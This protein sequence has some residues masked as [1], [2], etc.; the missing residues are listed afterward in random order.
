MISFL[1]FQSEQENG[2]KS[3]ESEEEPLTPKAIHSP[4]YQMFLSDPIKNGASGPGGPTDTNTTANGTLS[5]SNLSQW[6]S[7]ES[8]TVRDWDLGPNRVSVV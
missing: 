7:M 5:K 3:P 6:K 4:K 1:K 8:L 2:P